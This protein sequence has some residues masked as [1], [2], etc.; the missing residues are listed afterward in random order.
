MKLEI[1]LERISELAIERK[2]ENTSFKNF[3]V[4]QNVEEIDIIVQRISEEVNE[5]IDCTECGNC[6]ANLRPI[7][8]YE[9]MSPFVTD[10]NFD[11]YK[12]L[13]SFSCK[14]L[15]DKKCTD[16]LNRPQ[17]CKSFPYM[18]R[19]NYIKRTHEIL[20]NYEICPIVFN[21]FEQLKTELA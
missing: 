4:T 14:K 7:A 2:E 13:K 16:Y 11:A 20:Q 9:E 17:E 3:L 1:N 6:C 15:E 8:T 21:V 12:Y 10:E 18:D 5:K 19:K